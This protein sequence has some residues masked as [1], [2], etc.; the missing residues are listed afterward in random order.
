MIE[1]IKKA[2]DIVTYE[3]LRTMLVNYIVNNAGLSKEQSLA[4]IALSKEIVFMGNTID[5]VKKLIEQIY[6]I[7]WESIGLPPEGVAPLTPEERYNIVAL[8]Y[9]MS[10]NIVNQEILNLNEAINNSYLYGY[11]VGS[12]PQDQDFFNV[13][14][15]NNFI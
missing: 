7:G 15:F 9:N 14:G 2:I 3:N 5:E 12:N 8:L 13:F 6:S 11:G 1:V 10:V 4:I